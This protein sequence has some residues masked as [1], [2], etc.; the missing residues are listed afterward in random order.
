MM[1]TKKSGGIGLQRFQPVILKTI[2]T[3]WKPIPPLDLPFV[4]RIRRA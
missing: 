4:G 2:L 1:P 3:G